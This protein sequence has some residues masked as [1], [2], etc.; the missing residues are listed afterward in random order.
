MKSCSLALS[1]LLH[2][3]LAE[4]PL[5]LW[6]F[7]N[8]GQ[9]SIHSWCNTFLFEMKFSC[10]LFFPAKLHI[11][12]EKIVTYPFK[13]TIISR[14][15]NAIKRLQ[16][17]GYMAIMLRCQLSSSTSPERLVI[18]SQDWEG[19]SPSSLTGW[20]KTE[21]QEGQT[22]QQSQTCTP[23]SCCQPPSPEAQLMC[24]W[25]PLTCMHI[26]CSGTETNTLH[27]FTAL[28]PDVLQHFTVLSI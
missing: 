7:A 4:H 1:Q 17:S 27:N 11:K 3:L 9:A 12:E 18:L 19:S 21:P 20:P 6:K 8:Q 28:H 14:P 2:W 24:L 26:I 22:P 23:G 13:V 10:V 15:R 16:K 25:E 5:N